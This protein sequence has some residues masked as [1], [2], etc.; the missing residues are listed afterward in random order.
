MTKKKDKKIQTYAKKV[1]LFQ[2][3]SGIDTTIK[4]PYAQKVKRNS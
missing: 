4:K 3:Q 2:K 1:L